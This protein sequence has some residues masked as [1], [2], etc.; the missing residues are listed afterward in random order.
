MRHRQAAATAQTLPLVQVG[1]LVSV[2]ARSYKGYVYQIIRYEGAKGV[3]NRSAI[4]NYVSYSGPGE[5]DADDAEVAERLLTRFEPAGPA[6]AAAAAATA[7]AA[8]A[9]VAAGRG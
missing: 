4:L 1:A 2:K 3:G 8:A 7:D 9:A 5:G 6:T